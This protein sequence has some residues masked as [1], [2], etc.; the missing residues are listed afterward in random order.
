M[1]QGKPL[2]QEDEGGGRPEAN[3]HALSHITRERSCPRCWIDREGNE[4]ESNKELEES[5][6]NI[7]DGE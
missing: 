3:H 5:G 1:F 6:S 7:E 2:D 4:R